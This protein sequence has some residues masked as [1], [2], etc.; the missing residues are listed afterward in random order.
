MVN[1]NQLF[2]KKPPQQLAG[3]LLK[4][5][6]ISSFRDKKEITIE[7]MTKHKT[8]EKFESELPTLREYYLPCKAKLFL[9]NINLKNPKLQ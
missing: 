3:R 7:S 6:G 8:L 1:I 2:L 4:H 5:L 9:E